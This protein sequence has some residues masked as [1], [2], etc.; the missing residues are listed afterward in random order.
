MNFSYFCVINL[1]ISCAEIHLSYF[2]MYNKR[3]AVLDD[4]RR[5][6]RY[7]IFGRRLAFHPDTLFE[8]YVTLDGSPAFSI[9]EADHLNKCLERCFAICRQN[10]ADIY[11]VMDCG[12]HCCHD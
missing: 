4:V 3:L 2:G 5:F 8:D 11:A 9:R 10:D 6:A 12:N 7:L 1:C